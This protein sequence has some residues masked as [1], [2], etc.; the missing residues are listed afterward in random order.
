[1]PFKQPPVLYNEEGKPRTVG[2]ELEYANLGIDAS[3]KIVQA[4]YG[5]RIEQESRFRLQVTDTELGDFTIEFD[6]TLLTEQRYKKAFEA[7]NIQVDTIKVGNGTLQDEV[8]T[9]LESIVG[10][11]FPY[12]IAC[13]PLPC[14]QLQQLEKLREALYRHH[15]EGTTSFVTNAFGTHINVELPDTETETILT[16]LRA[17][18][19]LYPW[20]LYV[21]HTDLARK[22]SPFIDPYPEAYVE[23][24][25]LPAYH[26]NLRDLIH[27]YHTFNPN[28]NRPLDM[29][30]LFAAL[31][32]ELLKQYSD[33]GK[34]KARKT[35][36]YRLP[37]SSIAQPDWT[38]AQEWNNWIR[39]EELAQDREA[40][41]QLSQEY[42][43]LK[44]H[45]LIGFE[46]KWIKRIEQW[47]P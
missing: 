16:Y 4:L 6:L 30:P 26:P 45:T 28:R 25:L 21:G 20:L 36:H 23:L 40:V 15:A 33:I 38:L 11:I 13:P 41:R 34:V 29:Y 17:F 12:E 18:V 27:D 44:K 8:E 43:S 10:K 2:F 9:A 22:I 46:N 32:G 24:V 47:L 35:F 37:N 14:T 1:M 31:E 5:G 3:A 39:V 7:F 19:L 42:L